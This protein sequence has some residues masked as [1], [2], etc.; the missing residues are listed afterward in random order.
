[1]EVGIPI[2]NIMKKNMTLITSNSN[3]KKQL[4]ATQKKAQHTKPKLTKIRIPPAPQIHIQRCPLSLKPISRSLSLPLIILIILPPT[5]HKRTL[6]SRH[7]RICSCKPPIP[8]E[9][10]ASYEIAVEKEEVLTWP[11]LWIA[12][13]VC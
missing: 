10:F 13:L 12:R 8:N 7:I 11:V 1:M 6:P 2:I 5:H 4:K 3:G 9:S